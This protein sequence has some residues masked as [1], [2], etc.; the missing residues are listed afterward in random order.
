[1]VD[2]EYVLQVA[3]HLRNNNV[4][5]AIPAIYVVLSSRDSSDPL[6]SAVRFSKPGVTQRLSSGI[7]ILLSV[8]VL[9]AIEEP[10]QN[11]AS[12]KNRWKMRGCPP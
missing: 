10:S 2:D 8:L 1:M 6:F 12:T 3:V 7:S 11:I 4:C 5:H 9:Q